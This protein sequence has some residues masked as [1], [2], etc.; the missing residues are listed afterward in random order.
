M[1]AATAAAT[2][3][4]AARSA[5]AAAAGASKAP[6]HKKEMALAAAHSALKR[7]SKAAGD[8]VDGSPD[9]GRWQASGS[10]SPTIPYVSSRLMQP[11]AS[12]TAKSRYSGASDGPDAH[13]WSPPVDAPAV[14]ASG[15]M[16]GSS[17]PRLASKIVVPSPAAAPAAPSLKALK[18]SIKSKVEQKA[19]ATLQ[20]GMADAA[21]VSVSCFA[22]DWKQ[23]L[24]SSWVEVAQLCKLAALCTHPVFLCMFLSRS[25]VGLALQLVS[26]PVPLACAP[27]VWCLLPAAL[28]RCSVCCQADVVRS[29][30]L[31]S[32]SSSASRKALKASQKAAAAAAE[33]ELDLDTYDDEWEEEYYEV[34]WGRGPLLCCTET[35]TQSASMQVLQCGCQAAAGCHL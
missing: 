6:S 23:G 12:S 5:A 33:E 32:S 14:E 35:A 13:M 17:R 29:S 25:T 24:G 30:K 8:A 34:S 3:A 28:L 4:A 27:D 7:Y 11:T 21:A 31:G 15:H 22:K 19:Q 9:G 1:R 10:P 18:R 16:A 2:S 20:E 26:C